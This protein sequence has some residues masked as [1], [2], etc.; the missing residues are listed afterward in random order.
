MENGTWAPT[1]AKTMMKMIQ[2]SKNLRFC[3]NSVKILSAQSD[4]SRA[5]IEALAKE[6]A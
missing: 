4:A 3:E 1:A 2:G 5:Q 6:L